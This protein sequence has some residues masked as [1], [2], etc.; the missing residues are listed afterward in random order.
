MMLRRLQLAPR[1][2][3]TSSAAVPSLLSSHLTMLDASLAFF[4]RLAQTHPDDMF[5]SIE[6]GSTSEI[7]SARGAAWSAQ[8]GSCC[9]HSLKRGTVGQE[10]EEGNGQK[11]REEIQPC[12]PP[13]HRDLSAVRIRAS[14]QACCSSLPGPVVHLTVHSIVAL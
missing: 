14:P 5:I 6:N 3:S 8:G 1:F 12:A 10:R 7:R 13:P 4:V 11:Q 2:S 9:D